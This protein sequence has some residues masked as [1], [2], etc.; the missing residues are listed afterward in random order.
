[1]IP[2]SDSSS[3]VSLS[4]GC[5]RLSVSNWSMHRAGSPLISGPGRSRWPGLCVDFA[6]FRTAL[7]AS[8]GARLTVDIIP[9][10]DPSDLTDLLNTGPRFRTLYS[11]ILGGIDLSLPFYNEVE[12]AL[13]SRSPHLVMHKFGMKIAG[14]PQPT[15]VLLGEPA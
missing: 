9:F 8:R 10:D 4:P 7:D 11:N 14:V 12:K 2:W 15:L 3:T 5:F 13:E 6:D 1:M